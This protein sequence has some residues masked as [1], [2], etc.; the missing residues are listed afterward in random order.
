MIERPEKTCAMVVGIGSYALGKDKDLP[1]AVVGAQQFAAWLKTR[2]VDEKRI[3]LRINPEADAIRDTLLALK[4]RQ[5][6]NT[7]VVYWAGHGFETGRRERGLFVA[8]TTSF[9]PRSW[10]VD[11]MCAYLS[12]EAPQFKTQ[13]AIIDACATRASSS[14]PLWQPI[15]MAEQS[16]FGGAEYRWVFAAPSGRETLYPNEGR[17]SVFTEHLLELLEMPGTDF[18]ALVTELRKNFDIAVRDEKSKYW[19]ESVARTEA[20]ALE[21]EACRIQ[22]GIGLEPA[23]WQALAKRVEGSIDMPNASFREIVAKIAGMERSLAGQLCAALLL[24]GAEMAGRDVSGAIRGSAL[25]APSFDAAAEMVAKLKAFDNPS[26]LIW[27]DYLASGALGATGA[28]FFAGAEDRPAEVV[29]KWETAAPFDDAIIEVTDH[30]SKNDIS[31]ESVIHVV[32]PLKCLLAP[33]SDMLKTERDYPLV[34]RERTRTDWMDEF[35]TKRPKFRDCLRDVKSRAALNFR[36]QW[37]DAGDCRSW[38]SVELPAIRTGSCADA[39]A[40]VNKLLESLAPFAAITRLS[41]QDS[42]GAREEELELAIE[43][44]TQFA[45]IPRRIYSSRNGKSFLILPHIT[46]IWDDRVLPPGYFH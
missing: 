20:W 17:A 41:I 45:N 14:S 7:I 19:S 8:D 26:Y 16:V 12:S 6:C 13:I 23:K 28:W 29:R 36:L 31:S 2:G 40:H 3:Y 27:T 39:A 42:G 4:A 21:D 10:N 32:A 24:R 22:E 44:E 5:D 34:F 37:F 43:G 35:R 30:M 25:L 46:L 33:Q 11:T 18:S 38:R 15:N 9:A 1:G